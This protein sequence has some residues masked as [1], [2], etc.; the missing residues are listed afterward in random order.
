MTLVNTRAAFE[1]AITDTVAAADGTVK[2]IYDNIP[3]TVP[4][5]TTK[6]IAISIT[7]N[8]P[9][10]QT[11][12]GSSDFYTGT[13]QCNIY[14]PRS[15]GTATM[16]TLGGAVIDGMT[17]VNGTGYTDSFG[18]S[19]R[20]SEVSG[21]IPVEIEDQSHFLGIISCQFSANT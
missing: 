15:T 8:Q 19:P 20:V 10:L 17:S 4:S 21:P 18:C 2:I 16:S 13:V 14:V 6:Y 1:K 5:K 9:T 3:Y 11:Q 7:Y 12:G